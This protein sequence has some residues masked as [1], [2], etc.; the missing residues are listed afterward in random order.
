[1]QYNNKMVSF[2]WTQ[3][4]TSPQPVCE[5]FSLLV[6]LSTELKIQSLSLRTAPPCSLFL[7][8]EDN[9]QEIMK[10]P[11]IR[12]YDKLSPSVNLGLTIITPPPCDPRVASGC[13]GTWLQKVRYF[14]SL[15]MDSWIP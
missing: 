8:S 9:N 11:S 7:Y 2:K 1:M 5:T 6:P 14:S 15:E 12:F 3:F 10:S 13:N 4:L